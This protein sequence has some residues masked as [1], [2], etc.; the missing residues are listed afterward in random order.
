MKATITVDIGMVVFIGERNE[1][2]MPDM[3]KNLY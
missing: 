3:Q 1:K 2:N